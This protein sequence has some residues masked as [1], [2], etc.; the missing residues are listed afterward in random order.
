MI[1]SNVKALEGLV[2]GVALGD[3]LNRMHRFRKPPF[4]VHSAIGTW[5]LSVFQT[6]FGESDLALKLEILAAPHYALALRG[7]QPSLANTLHEAATQHPTQKLL[8]DIL[9]CMMPLAFYTKD[10]SRLVSK[11]IELT[12]VT[13]WHPRVIA[14]VALLLGAMRAL[15][16]DPDLPMEGQ[17]EQGERL[18]D[19]TLQVLFE[20]KEADSPQAIWAAHQALRHHVALAKGAVDPSDLQVPSGFDARDCPEQ[21]VVYVLALAQQSNLVLEQAGTSDIL[22]PLLMGL[23]GLR[24][25]RSAFS[26]DSFQI[27]K[28]KELWS[29]HLNALAHRDF[30]FPC[31]VEEEI[32]LS[33]LEQVLLK[34]LDH[35]QIAVCTRNQLTLFEDV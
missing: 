27:L 33:R 24:Q 25:G 32:K 6:V 31:L 1:V 21:L 15:L 13:H 18:A 26:E 35:F 23:V 34:E 5:F 19:K 2:W 3:G 28:G 10:E 17:L 16:V 4:L 20:R 11:I 29:R 30:Y 9:P 7:S 22:M 8:G 12:H 14:S